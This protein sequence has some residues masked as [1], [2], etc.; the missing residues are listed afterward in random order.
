MRDKPRGAE[1]HCQRH[2][3]YYFCSRNINKKLELVRPR[4]ETEMEVESERESEHGPVLA[5]TSILSDYHMKH[6]CMH[7]RPK[8]WKGETWHRSSVQ[9]RGSHRH[10]LLPISNSTDLKVFNDSLVSQR[11]VGSQFFENP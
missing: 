5:S 11:N 4:S 8:S 10:C 6:H 3:Y 1:E 9:Q 2:D 7:Y